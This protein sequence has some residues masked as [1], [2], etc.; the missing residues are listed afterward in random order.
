[1][2]F[3]KESHW[4]AILNLIINSLVFIYLLVTF[5]SNMN[6]HWLHV[7]SFNIVIDLFVNRLF[8]L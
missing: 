1:M 8:C 3:V 7:N 2:Y 5:I 4:S 6:G